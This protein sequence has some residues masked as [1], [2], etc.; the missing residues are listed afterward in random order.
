MPETP[1]QD[2]KTHRRWDPAYHYF[3][4]P[5]LVVAFFVSLWQAFKAPSGWTIWQIF[6]SAAV[7]VIAWKARSFALRAQDRVI[8]LEE[9]E[10]LAAVLDGPLR[11]RS[12]SL[13]EDQLIGLRFA[14]DAELAGLVTA[15]LDEGLSGEAI[16]KR[17]TRW[18]PDFFR[19]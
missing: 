8:R 3:A 14:S 4:A 16:K 19:V 7:V 5:V 12:L 10:R 17:I 11:A 15:A 9:R 18:R 6:V 1:T 13:T 2:F